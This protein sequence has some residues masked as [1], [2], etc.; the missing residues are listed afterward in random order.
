MQRSKKQSGEV[1][2]VDRIAILG[3]GSWGTALAIALGRAGAPV[4]LWGRDAAGMAE[5]SRERE[6][7]RY[8]PEIPIPDE[9]LITSELSAA[10]AGAALIV[11]TV[12]TQALRALT[13]S[14][15]ATHCPIVIAAKGLEVGTGLRASQIV[16]EEL[17]GATVGIL[18]GPSFAHELATGKPTAVTLALDDSALAR[19]VAARLAV[20][21]FR[22]YPSTDMVGVEIGGAFKNVVAIAAGIAMGR[23]LGENA[24]AAVV[25]RGLAE[26]SR[27]AM[28]LGA[29]PVTLMGLSGLGDL[30]LTAT[31]LTSRNTAFGHALGQGRPIEA[32]LA[33]GA[34]LVEGAYTAG[35]A[36]EL[37][38]SLGIEL[39]IATGV[40]QVIAGELPIDRVI[41]QLL[42]RPL[43]E[44]E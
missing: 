13:R 5:L 8:L 30:L 39:P 31:S 16:R 7:L 21:G 9:V 40:A 18:S 15:P 14:L 11:L 23:G 10:L 34:K 1:D 28:A 44:R 38:Q 43:P 36:V 41:E 20:P 4:S 32:L 35:A 27:L 19:E 37:G 26:L 33:P 6:S 25:T 2:S 29:E 17:A 3:A 42:A 24:R 22:P 12:P